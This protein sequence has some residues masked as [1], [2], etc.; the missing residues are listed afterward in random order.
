MLP[1]SADMKIQ[2]CYQY[3]AITA[4]INI[5]IIHNN[6]THQSMGYS[7][8]S[9]ALYTSKRLECWIVTVPLNAC[10]INKVREN[11]QQNLAIDNK[12]SLSL[13]LCLCVCVCVTSLS[14]S[15]PSD[16]PTL[17]MQPDGICMYVYGLDSIRVG[18]DVNANI[19]MRVEMTD[20]IQ[21][22]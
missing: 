21:R 22:V 9:F 13:S 8:F 12:V 5:N 6:T 10:A 19:R 2:Y 18:P 11:K 17:P 1:Q 15:M 4:I 20:G 14:N 7:M 3:Q 16:L